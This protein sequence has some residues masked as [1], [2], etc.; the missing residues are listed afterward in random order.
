MKAFESSAADKTEQYTVATPK[1]KIHTQA[2]PE[3]FVGEDFHDKAIVE[4]TV[5]EG[6]KIGFELFKQTGDKPV[7]EPSNLVFSS[8]FVDA[9]KPG[10][11]KSEVTRASEPGKYYW[12]ESAYDKNGARIHRGECGAKNET[13][14][15]KGLEV[16][17][18]AVP[19]VELGDPAHDTAIVKGK[20]PSGATVGFEAFKQTGDKPVCEP[21]NRVFKS[22]KNTPLKGAGEYESETTVFK[23][24]GTYYWVETVFDHAGKVL[25]RGECGLPN[26]TTRVVKTPERPLAK[27]GAQ[28]MGVALGALAVTGLGA[29]AY[30][31]ARRRMN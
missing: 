19:E 2:V 20:V 27:T 24:E 6:M 21:G 3:A 28:V 8:K 23:E 25:H 9:D 22:S 29:G 18:K 10:E 4:G 15:V 5:P 11:Y 13:T 1:V 14:R 16:T 12:V 26:E 7:C 31:T 30:Y 17:T